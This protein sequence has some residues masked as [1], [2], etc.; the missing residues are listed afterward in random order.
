MFQIEKLVIASRNVAKV[1]HYQEIFQGLVGSVVGLDEFDIKN[2][3][4]ESGDTAEDNAE[5]KAK[6]YYQMTKLPVFSEDES[7][8]V[9]FLPENQQPGTF[10]RRINGKNEASD[11]EL[12]A[13]WENII[14]NVPKLK[15]TGHWHFAY[16]LINDGQTKIISQDRPIKFFYPS[17]KIRIPGWPLS[18]LSGSLDKPHSEYTE[19]EEEISKARDKKLI[20]PILKQLIKLK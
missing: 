9:D 6:F 13:Y 4:Q 7:L 17:S 14:K 11:N 18:S 1:K 19:K 12:L 2:K 15:R 10:V 8:F 20:E 3:P 16:C 5:I